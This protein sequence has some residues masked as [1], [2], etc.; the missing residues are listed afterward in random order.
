MQRVWITFS[1]T[2]GLTAANANVARWI[3]FIPSKAAALI[4][5]T[6][7]ITPR[8]RTRDELLRELIESMT[9]KNL[10]DKKSAALV[11]L[12]KTTTN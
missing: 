4:N 9:Q 10:R 1:K 8:Q 11:I 3:A 2:A 6:T 5:G 12:A 7:R